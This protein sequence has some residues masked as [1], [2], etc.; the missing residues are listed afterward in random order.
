MLANKSSL[1]SIFALFIVDSESKPFADTK[2]LENVDESTNYYVST[3]VNE[4]WL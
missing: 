2:M 3:K 1:L 4:T